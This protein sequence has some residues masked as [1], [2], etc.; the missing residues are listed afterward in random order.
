VSTCSPAGDGGKSEKTR[1]QDALHIRVQYLHERPTA[2]REGRSCV[3]RQGT[4]ARA[5]WIQGDLTRGALDE[6]VWEDLDEREE[7]LPLPHRPF[8][9][10]HRGTTATPPRAGTP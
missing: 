2:P 7:F 8:V 4:N 5:R 1:R 9:S 3:A 10:T 6:E